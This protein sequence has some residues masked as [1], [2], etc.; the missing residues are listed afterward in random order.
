[1]SVKILHT[2]DLHIG[3]RFA[4]YPEIQK[5]LA[6]ARFTTLQNLITLANTEKCD[7]FVVAGDLFDRPSV[8]K[9][10]ILKTSHI[11]QEF[12]GKLVVVLPGNH[13]YVSGSQGD[14]WSHFRENSSNNILVL[15]EKKVYQLKPYDIDADIYAAPCNAKHSPENA[16][17][18]M[19]DAPK[20]KETAH[21][22]GVAH[23]SLEGFSPDFDNR[24]YPMT[25]HEL[26]GCGLDL[27]LLGHTHKHYPAVAGA[28]DIIFYSGTPEPDGFDCDHNGQAWIIQIDDN[29]KLYARLLTTG[30]HRFLH[31][32]ANIFNADDL[33]MLSRK[34]KA[35]DLQKTL[36]K[37]TISGRLP[38]EEYSLV[39]DLKKQLKTQLLYLTL[40]DDDL[41][42]E[43]TID[44]INR[45]FTEGSFPHLL[46]TELSGRTEALQL[47]YAMLQGV[48]QRS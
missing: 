6:E 38:K 11:L 12:E 39:Q 3:M 7:L 9:R 24:Y 45:E 4:G 40:T 17:A 14:L 37:L 16:I 18:W 36:L 44:R 13:D 19:K 35:Q 34:F 22:I 27:W 1:M 32:E 31:D 30:Q 10:D 2:S 41:A 5:E 43:I 47:A 20:D 48:R 33:S 25:P 23:G 8:A 21:H 42:E 28:R 46:L 15:D 26:N 29:K